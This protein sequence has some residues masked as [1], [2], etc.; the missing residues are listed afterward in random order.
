M[1][2]SAFALARPAAVRPQY[3]P[4]LQPSKRPTEKPS[5]KAIMT[6]A[7]EKAGLLR[8]VSVLLVA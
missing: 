3:V 6:A 8:R 2:P 1:P 7:L 4:H 5:G